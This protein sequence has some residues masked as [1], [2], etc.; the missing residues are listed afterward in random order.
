MA[1]L[2]VLSIAVATGR[3]GYVLL[4]DGQLQDWGMTVKSVRSNND[5]VG[6]AQRL[7]NDLQPDVFVTEDVSA[8]SCRKGR[9]AKTMINDLATLASHN[10]VLDVSVARPRTYPS[11]HE[12]AAALAEIHPEL[13]GYL[14]ARK[15][16]IF[17]YEPRGMILFE[18]L[19]LASEVAGG[20]REG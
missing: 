7:I 2:S 6:F 20:S 5:L 4:N 13:A 14:P 3:A 9:R 19:V 15:R 16:R 10:E 12:E 11:K 8:G 17:D 1:A 18:A